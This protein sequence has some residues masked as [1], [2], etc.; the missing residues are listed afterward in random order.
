MDRM[1]LH[2]VIRG[3]VADGVTF[4][5]ASADRLIAEVPLTGRTWSI[6]LRGAWRRGKRQDRR[7]LA[8]GPVPDSQS[9]LVQFGARRA[10]RIGLYMVEH[11]PGALHIRSAVAHG[12]DGI[13]A[14]G[15]DACIVYRG[16]RAVRM[17]LSVDRTVQLLGVRVGV[18]TWQ[19]WKTRR[20]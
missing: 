2:E 13:G 7:A 15:D 4:D 5:G 10:H 11:V 18:T 19:P 8:T 1:A 17:D 9:E 12:L 14:D 20:D 3:L 16:K 6:A